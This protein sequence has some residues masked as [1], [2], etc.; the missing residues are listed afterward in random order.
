MRLVRGE[1]MDTCRSIDTK[2][3][4]YETVNYRF[5]AGT[6]LVQNSQL[7]TAFARWPNVRRRHSCRCGRTTLIG[8]RFHELSSENRGN[9][10]TMLRN[11]S[12]Y[13]QETWW[14][15]YKLRLHYIYTSQDDK[16]RI[17][18]MGSAKPRERGPDPRIRGSLSVSGRSPETS[19]CRTRSFA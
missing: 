18:R 15:I 6:Q 3:G 19:A 8:P 14:R 17:Y 5:R 16:W 2:L 4:M 10:Q 1:E 13:V 11:M 9:Q 12:C 7:T